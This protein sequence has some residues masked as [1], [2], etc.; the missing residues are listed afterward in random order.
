MKKNLNRTLMFAAATLTLGAA[1]AYGQ[2]K[3]TANIPFEFRTADG[4]H[5]AGVYDVLSKAASPVIMLRDEASRN[6]VNLRIGAPESATGE[7]QPRL[8]FHCFDGAGC[9]LSQI[10]TG[11]GQGWSY[12]APE[13]KGLKYVAKVVYLQRDIAR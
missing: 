6:A 3:I 4:V 9:V 13:V 2:E 10:W 1:A 5:A 12:A 8:V 7:T 11:N